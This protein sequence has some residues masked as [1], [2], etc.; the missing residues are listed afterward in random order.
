[1]C[2]GIPG[3]ITEV[4]RDGNAPMAQADF[5]GQIRSVC[6]AYLPDLKV[7]DYIIA[8]LGY[9]VTLIDADDAATTLA[10]LRE[11]GVLDPVQP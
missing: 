1:M 8:H 7:G 4:W 2:L 3:Q 11:Y 6:L 10:V 9:A 5:A